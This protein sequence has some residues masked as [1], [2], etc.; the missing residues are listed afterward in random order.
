ML[1][2]AKGL[3]VGLWLPLWTISCLS[4]SRNQEQVILPTVKDGIVMLGHKTWRTWLIVESVL[5]FRHI[6]FVSW[7]QLC[8]LE[9]F[10][11]HAHLFSTTWQRNDVS[12]VI[13]FVST[14]KEYPWIQ[15][16]L[17]EKGLVAR[18]NLQQRKW[19]MSLQASRVAKVLLCSTSWVFCARTI[20]QSVTSSV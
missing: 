13:H 15:I 8:L 6:A 1:D 20:L 3:V 16:F 18:R 19:W 5:S 10:V 9:V 12:G 11:R 7:K 17:L 14:T 2:K 4:V